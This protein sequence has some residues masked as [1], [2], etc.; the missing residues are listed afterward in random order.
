MPLTRVDC[1][2]L[3]RNESVSGGASAFVVLNPVRRPGTI[4]AAGSTAH[5]ENIGSQVACKLAIEHFVEGVLDRFSGGPE[6][7]STEAGSELSV[8]VLEMAFR[9][10]NSSV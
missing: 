8:E 4:V 9:R 5:R 10:A 6:E 7:D 2:Y 3:N 1:H